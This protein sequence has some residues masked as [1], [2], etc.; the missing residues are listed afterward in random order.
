MKALIN[1]LTLFLLDSGL[2]NDIAR[3]R[4]FAEGFVSENA[5]MLSLQ[6]VPAL[7]PAVQTALRRD[8][9]DGTSREVVTDDAELPR[10]IVHKVPVVGP[11]GLTDVQRAAVASG[12]GLCANCQQPKNRH[13][14]GCARASGEDPK[15]RTKDPL[16]PVQ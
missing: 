1:A 5:D 13:L 12:V 3:A 2:T 11:D 10:A 8:N 15:A 14:P 16:P 4:V 7:P 9:L 6:P